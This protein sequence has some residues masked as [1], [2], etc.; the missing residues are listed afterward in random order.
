[1]FNLHTLRTCILTF[2]AIKVIDIVHIGYII[3][4]ICILQ[5][6]FDNA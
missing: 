4:Y 3:K 5:C 6:L 2:L 1:M